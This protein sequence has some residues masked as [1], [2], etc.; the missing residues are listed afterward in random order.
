MSRAI[1]R[2]TGLRLEKGRRY[3]GIAFDPRK[4]GHSGLSEAQPSGVRVRGTRYE[5]ARGADRHPRLPGLLFMMR[6]DEIGVRKFL[7][8]T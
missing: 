7:K 6:L 1:D 8:E 3:R 4:L 5:V 2:E